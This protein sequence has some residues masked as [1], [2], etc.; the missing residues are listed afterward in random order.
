[1]LPAGDLACAANC[2]LDSSA[3]HKLCGNA[4]VDVGEACDG[5]NLAGQDCAV[6]L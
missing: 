4:L 1:V 6:L 2:T 5:A 3:C